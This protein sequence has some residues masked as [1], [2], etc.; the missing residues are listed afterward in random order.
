MSNEVIDGQ[1]EEV[2][3]HDWKLWVFSLK[4]E[5]L[6]TVVGKDEPEA[7]SNVKQIALDHPEAGLNVMS[8]SLL[9]IV[10]SPF[11]LTEAPEG[12]ITGLCSLS[13]DIVLRVDEVRARMQT[14]LANSMRQANGQIKH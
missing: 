9:F 4:G 3:E 1:F 6:V 8:A 2:E 14:E 10:P 12:F 11:D 7:L 5:H 13:N